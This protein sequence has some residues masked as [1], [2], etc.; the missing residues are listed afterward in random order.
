MSSASTTRSARALILCAIATTGASA[1]AASTASAQAPARLPVFDVSSSGATKAQADR[2]AKAL[3]ISAQMLG[4]NGLLSYIDQENFGALPVKPVTTPGATRPDE[5]GTPVIAEAPD[6]DAIRRIKPMDASAAR[7]QATAALKAAGLDTGGDGVLTHS[8]FESTD[9]DGVQNAKVQ[10]DTHVSFPQSLGG[11]ALEGPGSKAKVVFGPEG[12]PTYVR[13][14]QRKLTEGATVALLTPT[15]ADALAK[16]RFEAG[17]PGQKPLDDLR[18]TRK[19]VYYAPSLSRATVE[20]IVP[21][22]DYGATATIA[23]RTVQLE[24]VLLP[25]VSSGAPKATLTAT[26]DGGRVTGVT[27]VSGG[28][29]PYRYSYSSCAS[30]LPDS[31]ARAGSKTSYAVQHRPGA[32]GPVAEKLSVTITDANGLTTVASDSVSVTAPAKA[33]IGRLRVRA[34]VGNRTDVGNEWIGNSQG[35]S[36]SADNNY[37]FR[38]EMSDVATISV[39]W[40]EGNVWESDFKDPALGGDDSTYADNVDLMWFQGHGN[41]DGFATNPTPGDGFVSRTDARWGNNDLEWLVVH[42]CSVLELGSGATHVQNRWRPAFRG[43]HMLL[44]YGNSSYNVDGDGNEFGDD[45]ADDDM[46]IRSAWVDANESEQPDG[47]IYRYMGVYGPNG[48][49]N[50]N[51]YFHGIGSVSADITTVTGAWSYSGTV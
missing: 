16:Q 23:G 34:A 22:Y 49:W 3:G 45:L 29:A 14:A 31:A 40:S 39:N 17:C 28:T 4:E 18:L 51:D 36:N 32:E 24:R 21:H 42:S 46:R 25:A 11:Y 35:L 27:K 12:K 48:E 37:D 7:S 13:Y 2:L 30:T 26:A 6:L 47:V 8:E 9:A 44:G 20:R 41:P 5:E 19:L 38:D 1:V 43:L 33:L 50:R 15:A 10:V